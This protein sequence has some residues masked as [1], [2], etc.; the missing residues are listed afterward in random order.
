VPG[1]DVVQRVQR[2]G[3]TRRDQRWRRRFTHHCPT[4]G[5]RR[6]TAR[7]RPRARAATVGR[8]VPYPPAPGWVVDSA[9]QGKQV[10]GAM[11]E[12]GR[13]LAQGGDD[14]ADP[15]SKHPSCWSR[16]LVRCSLP[17]GAVLTCPGIGE[18]CHPGRQ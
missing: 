9:G 4:T 14:R 12:Q 13:G 3:Q 10:V 8:G 18:G 15:T 11:R 7:R 17:S 5:A 1:E 2:R 6:C 16:M